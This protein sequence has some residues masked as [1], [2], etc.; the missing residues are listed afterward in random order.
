[1]S[2][3]GRS[4]VRSESRVEARQRRAG[5][6]RTTVAS[7]DAPP[8][9]GR[10]ARS[11]RSA[12][13]AHSARTQPPDRCPPHVAVRSHNGV[14]RLSRCWAWTRRG[15]LRWLAHYC[16][17]LRQ[18]CACSEPK[19]V[20][21]G[22]QRLNRHWI[23]RA[24]DARASPTFG[25]STE[26]TSSCRCRAAWRCGAWVRSCRTDRPVADIRALARRPVRCVSS[27]N[28]MPLTLAANTGRLV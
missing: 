21:A 7:G 23:V 11:L 10:L 24:G 16:G 5:D 13:S 22:R 26:A 27:G 1:M 14:G 9:P 4:A 8:L 18:P 19:S 6:R 12:A 15:S 28:R 25:P 20:H 17:P 3:R 2:P